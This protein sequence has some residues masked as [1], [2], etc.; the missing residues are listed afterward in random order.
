[1]IVKNEEAVL[2]RCLGSVAEAVEE[3]VIVDTGSTDRTVEIARRFTDRIF[4]FPWIDDFSAARNFSFSKA[5]M[6]Y[7]LWLDADDVL[8]KE[9]CRKLIDLKKDLTCDVVMMPYQSG[10]LTFYRERLLRR[11][12]GFLWVGAVHEAI[13]PRGKIQYGDITVRHQKL[14]PSDPE[15][16]LRIYEKM[17]AEGRLKSPRDRFYYARELTYHARCD[18]AIERLESLLREGFGWVEELLSACRL[19][20]SC[21]LK[22]GE[23]EK[24]VSWLLHAFSLAP[25]RAELCCDLG[26]LFLQK[27]AFETAVF[28]YRSAFLCPAHREGFIEADRGGIYPALQ[29]CVCYWRMGERAEAKRWHEKAAAL[30]PDH[31]AVLQN[32]VNGDIK[33]VCGILSKSNT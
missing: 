16:N 18:E 14:H 13:P 9:D 27:G 8:E 30:S 1:M 12:A 28:W 20:A 32:A 7:C 21:L 24:A 25:P 22:K 11:E 2:A 29:L 3:M 31:P 33:G 19:L 15:R 6:D 10:S 4:S 17:L 23:E 26:D 5:T